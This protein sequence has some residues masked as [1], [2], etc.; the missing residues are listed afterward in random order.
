MFLIRKMY[1]Q[2]WLFGFCRR[3]GLCGWG[4]SQCANAGWLKLVLKNAGREKNKKQCVGLSVGLVAV[5]FQYGLYVGVHL[6]KYFTFFRL[7]LLC[8]VVF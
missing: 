1:R 7:C 8:C 5:Q 2:N 3:V 4:K 6:S